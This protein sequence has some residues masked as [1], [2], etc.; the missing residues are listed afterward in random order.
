MAQDQGFRL[1]ERTIKV[2]DLVVYY[3]SDYQRMKAAAQQSNESG[4]TGY[5]AEWSLPHRVTTVKDKVVEVA[6]ILS[7][8]KPI[9]QVPITLIRVLG[10]NVPKS[11]EELNWAALQ[12]EAPMVS[13]SWRNYWRGVARSPGSS[14]FEEKQAV[15]SDVPSRKR[16]LCGKIVRPTVR[17]T[18]EASQEEIEK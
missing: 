10:N 5:S 13:A 16:R 1:K 18:V 3:L 11:L 14:G 17:S 9:R 8:T 7:P 12:Q 6:D 4:V 15:G 2:G